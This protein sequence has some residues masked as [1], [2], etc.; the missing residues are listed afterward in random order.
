MSNARHPAGLVSSIVPILTHTISL[1]MMYELIKSLL[2][3][4]DAQ[5]GV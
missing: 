4:G 1:F 5:S 2:M 3:R